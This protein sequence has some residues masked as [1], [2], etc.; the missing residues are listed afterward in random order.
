M[1]LTRKK[2]VAMVKKIPVMTWD[3]TK[4]LVLFM[5]EIIKN[6]LVMKDKLAVAQHHLKEVRMIDWPALPT[7]W[8]TLTRTAVI[9]FLCVVLV[10][11]AV[12]TDNW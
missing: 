10:S 4:A 2:A 11:T 12:A 8:L 6:P 7:R 1:A 3:A 9:F 5:L